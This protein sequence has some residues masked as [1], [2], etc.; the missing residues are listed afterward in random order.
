MVYSVSSNLPAVDGGW[1]YGQ[2]ERMGRIVA[3][4]NLPAL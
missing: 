4:Q 1:G 2:H 3:A